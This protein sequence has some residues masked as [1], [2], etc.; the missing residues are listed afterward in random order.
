MAT[1]A[2]VVAAWEASWTLA[3]VLGGAALLMA[4]LPRLGRR[5]YETVQ[6]DDAGVLRVDG[7]IREQIAWPDVTEIR[8]VTTDQGPYA[9]D[10]FFVLVG[11]DNRGCV[12]PHDAADRTGLYEE[13]KKRF[14]GLNDDLVIRAMGSTSNGLFVIWQRADTHGAESDLG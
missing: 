4:L 14:V 5:E 8:I 3:G 6:V 9:E 1:L 7:S 13:L 2:A 12:V 11:L 10:V